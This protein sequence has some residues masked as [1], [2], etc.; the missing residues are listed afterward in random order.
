MR[1]VTLFFIGF[2]MILSSYTVYGQ[3]NN[4]LPTLL[5]AEEETQTEEEPDCE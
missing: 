3:T 1:E 5:F 2:L 4:V